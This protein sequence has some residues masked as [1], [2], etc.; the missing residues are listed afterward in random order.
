MQKKRI[1]LSLT[2]LALFDVYGLWRVSPTSETYRALSA[3][4]FEHGNMGGFL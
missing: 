3:S 4:E 2:V 1:V